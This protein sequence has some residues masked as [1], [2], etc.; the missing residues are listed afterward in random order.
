MRAFADRLL[1]IFTELDVRISALAS[2]RVESGGPKIARAE[3][4]ILGQMSLLAD[5]K[6]SSV[7]TLAETG[8]LDA[9]LKTEYAVERELKSILKKHGLVYDETSNEIWIP[10]GAT[11]EPLLD[12]KNVVV[13]RIDAESAL[14]S[15]AVK[16]P[17]KNRILIQDALGSG[18]FPTL[19]ERIERHGGNLSYFLEDSET[20]K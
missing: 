17:T 16:A 9:L 3:V 4:R 10:T 14:T 5:Q 19:A 8:D 12:L 18:V 1:A 11:F 7:V 15:K 2:E 6:V 20:L 13:S